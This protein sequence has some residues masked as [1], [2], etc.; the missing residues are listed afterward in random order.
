M[1][2]AVIGGAGY[3]GIQTCRELTRRGHEVFAVT[4]ANGR[5]LLDGSGARVIAPSEVRKLGRVDVVLNL[6]YPNRGPAFEY[7][8]RNQEILG[9]VRILADADS[10][11]I[12]TSTQAVFGYD[13]EE[14]VAAQPVGMRR[15][16]AYIETK[17]ELEQLIASA[18]AS[19]SVD[20]VRLG[21][22]WGPASPTWTAALA[23]KLSF[24][25][26]VGV[27]GA[28]GFCNATD[29][30][31]VADY[32]ATVAERPR[33]SGAHFHHLAELSELRW[34]WWVGRLSERLGVTPQ[35]VDDR[36]SYPR[37][38]GEELRGTWVKHSPFAIARE[39]MYGRMSG[40]VYRSVVRSMPRAVHPF[41]RKTGKGAASRPLADAGDPLFLTL[42][43]APRRFVSA[44]YPDWIPPVSATS[45]WERVS[46]WL[47]EA[48]Y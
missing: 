20:V 17:I 30:A 9:M 25:D 19:H 24:G 40:S 42:V 27:R 14:P 47:D 37:S 8:E 4:R 6:A 22:V 21:N 15:D 31:N 44:V 43:S 5:V 38:F 28:D 11:V 3:V 13:L 1:R 26:V 2:V 7:P 12:H 39:W 35:F 10:K 23:D 32:L 18:F 45:S 33:E 46:A 48:G 34:S 29:V 16:F 41:L 36:P